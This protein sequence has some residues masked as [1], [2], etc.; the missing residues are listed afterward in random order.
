MNQ[1]I[2]E[3]FQREVSTPAPGASGVETQE[4]VSARIKAWLRST[5][6]QR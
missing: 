3:T 4:Q 6:M 2:K 1:P 5:Q